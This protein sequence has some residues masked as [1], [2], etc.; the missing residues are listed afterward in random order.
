MALCKKIYYCCFNDLKLIGDS[1][2]YSHLLPRHERKYSSRSFAH[3]QT[4]RLQ[5]FYSFF[6][7]WNG[8][9][10][11]FQI[12]GRRVTNPLPCLNI[13]SQNLCN[14]Y[15]MSC[16]QFCFYVWVYQIETIAAANLCSNCTSSLK[17]S[18]FNSEWQKRFPIQW[19]K[20]NFAI[21]QM[22]SHRLSLNKLS[23]L[24]L[25]HHKNSKI[26][27]VQWQFIPKIIFMKNNK[28]KPPSYRSSGGHFIIVW[29]KVNPQ[30][31]CQKVLGMR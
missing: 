12:K 19:L 2:N 1:L 29:P 3:D 20:F 6:F 8:L 25:P 13:W 9:H 31:A 11:N 23:T 18:N 4:A 7:K 27:K 26:W 22:S 16:L 14:K 10:C 24:D 15:Q 30:F 5:E 28:Y 21:N 17:K